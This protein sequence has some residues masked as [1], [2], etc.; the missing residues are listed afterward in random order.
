MKKKSL[1]SSIQYADPVACARAQAA[2]TEE[3]EDDDE[4][5]DEEDR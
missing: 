5:G 1:V 4:G 2:Y 3:D